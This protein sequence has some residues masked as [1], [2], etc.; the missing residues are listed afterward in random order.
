MKATTRC[1][2][3]MKLRSKS[4]QQSSDTQSETA[5]KESSV[6]SVANQLS[7][8]IIVSHPV[9]RG[10]LIKRIPKATNSMCSVVGRT[11]LG[12]RRSTAS[13]KC[14]SDL[15]KFGLF[16]LANPTRGGHNEV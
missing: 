4:R 7:A 1:F 12:G 13:V 2:Q 3:I 16:V 8:S 9:G 11:L 10:T 5:A 15:L 14:L 6:K